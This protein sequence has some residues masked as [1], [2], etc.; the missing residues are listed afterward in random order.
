MTDPDDDA[1][2]REDIFTRKAE[3]LDQLREEVRNSLYVAVWGLIM[4]AMGVAAGWFTLVSM[5][6]GYFDE[7]E[8]MVYVDQERGWFYTSNAFFAALGLGCAVLGGQ[9]L[10]H[11]RKERRRNARLAERLRRVGRGGR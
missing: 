2:T 10:L 6:R 3:R 1:L 5:R 7:G 4:L 9:M 11:A 8:R